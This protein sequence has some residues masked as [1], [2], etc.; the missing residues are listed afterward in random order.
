MPISLLPHN[1]KTYER[2][3]EMNLAG[4]DEV[5]PAI[6][7]KFYQLRRKPLQYRNERSIMI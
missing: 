4:E 1:A 6:C 5:Q 3:V 7:K 2:A